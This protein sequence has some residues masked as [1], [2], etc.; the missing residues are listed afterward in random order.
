MVAIAGCYNGTLEAGEKALRPLRAFEPPVADHITPTLYCQVQTLLDAATVRGRR[1]YM[2]SNM[3]QGISDD[4]IDTLI[5][6]LATIPSPFSFVFF[7][8]LGNAA[9]VRRVGW[10]R[11]QTK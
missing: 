2:K 5:E 11:R 8:Q 4:A 1:Y 3:T 10:I 6:R 9:N 7:Q